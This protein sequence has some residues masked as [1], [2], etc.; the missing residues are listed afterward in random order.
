MAKTLTATDRSALIRLAST[1]EAGD[2][3][4][5]AILAGL[6]TSVDEDLAPYQKL[7]EDFEQ[8]FRVQ[9]DM[10]AGE[11]V[12]Y[13]GKTVSAGPFKV[14]APL[15]AQKLATWL[16]KANVKNLRPDAKGIYLNW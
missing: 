11:K 1:M 9:L 16:K 14:F 3:K 15:D 12:R 5:L 13:F 7:A 8:K 2:P 6:K 10:S 4:R